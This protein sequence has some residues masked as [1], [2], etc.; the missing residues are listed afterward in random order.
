MTTTT[1]PAT[2]STSSTQPATTSTSSTQPATTSTT[3][4]APTTTV[5]EDAVDA[6]KVEAP[7]FQS[8]IS[9]IDASIADRMSASWRP[10]CPVELA[11]LR[12]L[13]VSHW[14]FTG[15]VAVGELIVHRDAAEDIV[16]VMSDLF[17]AQFPIEQMRLVDEYDGDDDLSMAANNTSAF[18]C[19]EVAWRPGVWSNH[20]FGNA[21]DINPLLNPYVSSRRI[22]PPE[23]E[24]YADRSDRVPGGIYP[25]D[26][27]VTAFAD[28]GWGWGG[29][30][31]DAKDW[32][33]FS[34]TGR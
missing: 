31:N 23:G 29:D 33:H 27:V 7:A 20:A 24:A 14:N 28:V 5:A 25:G 6:A 8:S 16:Q 13:Q 1:Q 34:S 32:Q 11:D 3:I 19:R 30:W 26:V 12:Y 18:N 22:L 4:E 10:G 21:I 2:T 17:A 15:G 9:A